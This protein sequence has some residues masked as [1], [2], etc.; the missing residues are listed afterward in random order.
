MCAAVAGGGGE[1]VQPSHTRRA[2][3]TMA[4]RPPS[5]AP[6]GRADRDHAQG[7]AVAGS[8]GGAR[9]RH[10]GLA[11]SADRFSD[12]RATPS[13]VPSPAG[14]PG[15]V[16]GHDRGHE[17]GRGAGAVQPVVGSRQAVGAVPAGPRHRR[18]RRAWPRRVVDGRAH[19]THTWG[20]RNLALAN[21]AV[22]DADTVVAGAAG[23]GRIRGCQLVAVQP[24]LQRITGVIA[25]DSISGRTF[26][27]DAVGDI[28][29]RRGGAE[30]AAA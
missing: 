30:T 13:A 3:N 7:R 11:R 5:L 1:G 10:P 26:E 21:V 17:R 20:A 22:V 14:Q 16:C 25:T 15:P 18:G 28:V 2:R 8:V 24:G 6:T 12:Q 9:R 19:G 4:W 29:V 23:A 27:M